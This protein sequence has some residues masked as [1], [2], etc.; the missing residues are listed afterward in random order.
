[1]V[2]RILLVVDDDEFEKL[3]AAKG[4]KTW[5]EFLVKERLLK[6]VQR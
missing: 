1:M 2:K 5:E 6:V 4:S 3:K